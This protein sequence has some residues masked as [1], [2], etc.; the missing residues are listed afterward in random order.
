MI[1]IVDDSDAVDGEEQIQYAG[2]DEES[3]TTI[4]E[5]GSEERFEEE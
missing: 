3:T 5:E 1:H 4:G 2:E